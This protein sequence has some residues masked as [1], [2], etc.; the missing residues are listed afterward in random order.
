MTPR[1]MMTFSKMVLLRNT[2]TV[3]NWLWRDFH[4]VRWPFINSANLGTRAIRK[5]TS[6]D[7][8]NLSLND[9]HHQCDAERSWDASKEQS[10]GDY[11]DSTAEYDDDIST[12]HEAIREVAAKNYDK[13]VNIIQKRWVLYPSS[14]CLPMLNNESGWMPLQ[15]RSLRSK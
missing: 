6:E 15:M 13:A 11:S 4:L 8:D 5:Q 14:Y 2:S 12:R 7:N 10:F 1:C 9:S 3:S